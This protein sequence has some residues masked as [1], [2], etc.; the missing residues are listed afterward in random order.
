MSPFSR[1]DPGRLA[2]RQALD[3]VSTPIL[4][5]TSEHVVTFAN[6]A[7]AA[8]FGAGSR[9]LEGREISD[10][11]STTDHP[12][13]GIRV[14]GERFAAT[15][16][17]TPL[18]RGAD[19]DVIAVITD[20]S[21]EERT[22]DRLRKF[23]LA[24]STAMVLVHPSGSIAL[25]NTCMQ[26]LFG[27]SAKELA[28]MSVDELVPDCAHVHHRALR[29]DFADHPDQ[30]DTSS[31]VGLHGKARDGTEIPVSISLSPVRFAGEDHVIASVT[32][33][34]ALE[35]EMAIAAAAEAHRL[36]SQMLGNLSFSVIAVDVEGRVVDANPAALSLL[37]FDADELIGSP[38]LS[39]HD[40]D[41]LRRLTVDL[42]RFR[43]KRSPGGFDLFRHLARGPQADE[44]ELTYVRRDGS[45]VAVGQVFSAMRDETG[46]LHGYLAV[47]HDISRRRE[48]ERSLV[49]L[50]DHDQLTGLP[51]RAAFVDRVDGLITSR[52]FG[53]FTV[54]MFDLDRFGRVNET[55]GHRTGDELLIAL[56][57][58]LRSLAPVEHLLA[59][60]GGDKF[61][62][63]LSESPSSSAVVTRAVRDILGPSVISTQEFKLGATIGAALFPQDATDGASLVRSADAALAG[64]K[65]EARGSMRWFDATGQRHVSR[66]VHLRAALPHALEKGELSM[67]Y[68]PV[69][70]L[71]SGMVVGVEAL[72]RW[73]SPVFGPVT[74]SEFIPIAEEDEMILI[75]GEWSLR[76]SCADIVELS[77]SHGRELTL[78]VN[79]S[80][81]Q[82][83]GDE[84]A[85][86]VADAL[87]TSGLAAH[88][89]ELEITE[90]I[91]IS[92]SPGVIDAIAAVQSQGVSVVL[93]D[94]GTGY[95]NFSYLTRFP[96]DK[97]KI[98]RSFISRL[99]SGGAD[100]AVVE[101]I[102]GMAHTLGMKVV[103][104]GVELPSQASFLKRHGCDE[105]QGFLYSPA[106][107]I[108]EL[109]VLA[110]TLGDGALGDEC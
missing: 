47:A 51:N 81:V 67:H 101:A 49:R 82:L 98:D 104:E 10:F 93:D 55:F 86:I 80:P 43:G 6:K 20:L 102:I 14:N 19:S 106:V 29:A 52:A 3:A 69:I 41:D 24:S 13:C 56:S 74:P 35:H 40:E 97:I 60:V 22:E 36:H 15:V 103:A 107:P 83:R 4:V 76:R 18:G 8:A 65:D 73:T 79:V 27:Y 71:E 70:S 90:N 91:F 108:E 48:V 32:D 44:R 84:W 42:G 25:S 9:F 87:N 53:A 62:F 61:A 16:E 72:A 23:V 100:A 109:S 66:A 1:T 50:T 17:L 92:H 21:E 75:F 30:H 5:L 7:A 95:S 57:Q 68:Q 33:I 77:R 105:A 34:R 88:R 2:I 110:E 99:V 28:G 39:L 78:A 59:R 63:V 37:G 12:S 94:F 64:A 38:F 31:R 89:L 54:V 58:R 45:T 96:L 11:I 46:R 85:D 26:L